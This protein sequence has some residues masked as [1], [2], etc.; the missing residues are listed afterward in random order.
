MRQGL[1]RLGSAL[2]GFVCV[3][4]P[5]IAGFLSTD[6]FLPAVGRVPGQGGAQFYTTVWVTNLGGAPVSFTF[7]FLKQGQAN[8]S[9]AS[10]A[11][12]LAPGETKVYENIIESKFGIASA[13]GAARI[14]ANGEILVSERI[15]DQPPGADVGNTKGLFFAGVPK[16][17]SISL[18]QSASIQGINQGGAENFRYNFA[19][20]ETGGGSPTVN[21]QL[22]DGSGT[23]LGQKSYV[24]QAYEQ[25][26]PNVTDITAGV[27]TTNARIT[28]TVTGGS[29]SV[30][31]AGAQLANE[32][33]D[34]SGFEMSFRDQLLGGGG[35]AGVTS[36]NGLTG[37]LTIAHGANTTVNVNGS[38]ITIDAVSGSGTGLTAVAHD[39]T[40]VGSGT[41]GV[42]LGIAP[43]S[44]GLASI[45]HDASLAG[46]GTGA[47]PLS[48]ASGQVVRS[49][50]VGA[51]T[52][53]DA[54]TLA[55]GSNVTLTPSG[56]TITIAASGGGG[57]GGLTLPFTGSFGSGTG[58]AVNSTA[59]SGVSI[60]GSATPGNADGVY[61]TS[62]GSGTGVKGISQTG[63]GVEGISAAGGS[64]TSVGVY[65]TNSNANGG[66]VGGLNSAT[67]NSGYLGGPYYGVYGGSSSRAGVYGSS[68]GGN[69]GY[70]GV[71]G[72]T[73][74]NWAGV[75]GHNTGSGNDGFL[76]GP[77]YGVFGTSSANTGV[78][79]KT[80]ANSSYGVWGHHN[81]SG[82]DGYLGGSEAGVSGSGGL[83]TIGVYG[84]GA[85]GVRGD[86]GGVYGIVGCGNPPVSGGP[87]AGCFAGSVE[88]NG[89]VHTS[90]VG[91]VTFD[92]PADPANE[93]ITHAF[94]G[95]SEMKNIYD[96]VAT[97]GPTGV[98]TVRLPGWF[99]TLNKDFR[100]QLT[101]LGT[102]QAGLFISRKIANN[103]FTIA[104]G[105]PGAEVSWQ[106]T[107]VRRD[108]WANAHPM[109]VREHKVDADR[110]FYIVPELYGQPK[111]KSADS[112]VR[113]RALKEEA[114]ERGDEP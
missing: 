76:G 84:I 36:L 3:T 74:G 19:L 61:G 65:G 85:N 46:A 56:S 43:G 24:M 94:V 80:S 9:P 38:T 90:A 30:L 86:S 1:A 95:S 63:I 17:F 33:Q 28:A 15:Y 50:T 6:T 12:T 45:T 55:A 83:L 67:G 4:A 42:P 49:L 100:Y 78:I 51:S 26:Q 112:I 89:T 22:L 59:N 44:G 70:A 31:L 111:T 79:G 104:G 98:A 18:G 97:L 32:S 66:G 62:A 11:D 106:V 14:V 39:N 108:P 60:W 71:Y 40:L 16:S 58:F 107:G 37:A 113:E 48:I 10:F 52:L 93:S 35:T 72:V 13:I 88:I 64:N 20:V 109:A 82:N 73:T 57:G 53:H 34:S 23:L 69:A 99:E 87:Y 110:G 2:A 103:Q 92:D 68:L 54:V 29:G 8:T 75:Q 7:D 96:G 91:A 47:S 77:D 102:P 41:A 114:A 101:A 25:F 105:V 27:H 81:P 21:V 5:A